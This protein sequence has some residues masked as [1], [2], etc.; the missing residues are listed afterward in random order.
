MT[1]NRTITSDLQPQARSS[2]LNLTRKWLFLSIAFVPQLYPWTQ[3]A[4]TVIVAA[5]AFMAGKTVDG[6][7]QLVLGWHSTF[8]HYET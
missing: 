5:Q 2:S 1:L 8:Q 6:P 7:S 4:M 3:L